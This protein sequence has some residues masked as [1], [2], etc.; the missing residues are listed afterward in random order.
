VGVT[1]VKRS[2]NDSAPVFIIGSYRSGTSVLTWCLGQHPNILA[3]EE[4]NWIAY[5]SVYIDNLFLLGTVNKEHSNL[6]SIGISEEEFNAY[7][8]RSISNFFRENLKKYLE[9]SDRRA[10]AHPELVS[11]LYQVSRV[12]G[13]P[14]DRW[15]DGTPENSHFV[16]GL[17]RLF[18][19]AKF[20]HIL[21]DPHDVARS[22]QHFSEAGGN[23][24]GEEEAYRT[25][26]R[27]VSASVQAEAALG[28]EKIMRVLYSDLNESPELVIGDC[29]NFIGEPFHSACLLP[30]KKKINSSGSGEWSATFRP[31]Q[32]DTMPP[33]HRE[34]S[35][36]YRHLL[37]TGMSSVRDEEVY[38]TF[39]RSFLDFAKQFRLEE[40]DRL[41]EWGSS[42]N[43]EIQ[44][45]DERI[46]ELQTE[47]DELCK[48]GK[49]LDAVVAERNNEIEKLKSQLE[50]RK[51]KRR[52]FSF[53]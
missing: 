53:T 43:D 47:V 49:D 30:L 14:K 20:I 9:A 33:Y 21:R 29:L 11:E 10:V 36:L 39:E 3:L 26:I 31:T 4:T 40:V 13:D 46:H 24:Y 2:D 17:A 16:Y 15:I 6:A 5:L 12:C 27:L 50:D 38:R 25:W 44:R 7:F 37:S 18:P 23:D 32:T 45:R 19:K 28:P 48:W 51:L 35:Q 22:L 52:L 42:L 1:T 41:A 34:A 8:G